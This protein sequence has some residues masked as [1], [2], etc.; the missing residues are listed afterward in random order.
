MENL[1]IKFDNST[2]KNTIENTF[3]FSIF[4]KLSFHKALHQNAS[5]FTLFVFLWTIL[6]VTGD[7]DT[8]KTSSTAEKTHC[9][10]CLT[11]SIQ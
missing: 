9:T 4:T 8:T 1:T 6:I 2:V 3:S 10:S 11:L 7:Q 5:Y